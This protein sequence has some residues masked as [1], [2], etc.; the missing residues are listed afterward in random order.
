MRNSFPSIGYG[1]SRTAIAAPSS[2]NRS[3]TGPSATSRTAST[4]LVILARTNGDMKDLQRCWVVK[5]ILGSVEHG[6][7]LIEIGA[8]E[9]L[10]ADLLTKLGHF[11]TVVDPYDG[12]SQG[13]REFEEFRSAHP[14]VELHPGALSAERR[15]AG[16]RRLRF[17]GLRP[18]AHRSR[19]HR[20]G[21]IGAAPKL[22]A[23]GG[24]SIHAIDHVV[25]GWGADAHLDRLEEIVQS[26]GARRRPAPRADRGAQSRSRRLLRLGRGAR[27]LARRAAL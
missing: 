19:R 11:V 10:V 8:G 7:H 17:L 18:G 9:P 4:I 13:P 14:D 6:A 24:C 26:L 2:P 5:A 21:V 23:P 20:P 22:V 16:R 1:S 15:P 12:S 3:P 25:A 27:A